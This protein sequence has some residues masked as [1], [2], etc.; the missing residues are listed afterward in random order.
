[1]ETLDLSKVILGSVPR[2][3]LRCSCG[4]NNWMLGF[5]DASTSDQRGCS[6]C[7]SYYFLLNLAAS[8]V[9]TCLLSHAVV[10]SKILVVFWRYLCLNNLLLH[11][12]CLNWMDGLD[13]QI[14]RLSRLK[15]R[16]D[17]LFN[18]LDAFLVYVIQDNRVSV[19]IIILNDVLGLNFLYT[20]ILIW[21]LWFAVLLVWLVQFLI[22]LYDFV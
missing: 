19:I 11:I 16:S 20:G 22:Y 3:Y 21:S 17:I 12:Y 18:V 7:I 14:D 8:P 6:M 1:M 13:L 2:R 15:I 9:A 5:L 4:D 10:E